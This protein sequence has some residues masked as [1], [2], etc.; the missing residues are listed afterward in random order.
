MIYR[1]GACTLDTQTHELYR[2]GQIVPL[3]PKVFQVLTYLIE[4]R[5]RLVTKQEL[6]AHVWLHQFVDDSV[7]ARCIMAARKA[8]GDT[9]GSPQSIITLRSQGYRFTAAVTGRV[10]AA[11][12]TAWAQGFGRPVPLP[13]DAALPRPVEDIPDWSRSHPIPTT[14]LALDGGYLASSIHTVEC[15]WVTALCCT[16]ASTTVLEAG[17]TPTGGPNFL[18]AFLDLAIPEVRRYGGTLQHVTPESFLTLFG[19]P[20]AYEDHAQRAVLAALGLRRCLRAWYAKAGLPVTPEP[21]LR[22]GLHTGLMMVGRVVDDVPI[23]YAAGEITDLAFQL[24]SGA[25]PG[26]IVASATTARLVR[27]MVRLA[28]LPSPDGTGPSPPLSSY[29]VCA[30]LPRR[31][32]ARRSG[33]WGL[34]PFAGRQRD[35]ATLHTL[36]QMVSAGRGQVVSIM[37]EPG[38]GKSRLLYE[39]CRSLEPH[40]VTYVA[41]ACVSYGRTIP[42]LPVLDVLRSHCGITAEDADAVIIAQVQRSLQEAGMAP[43]TWAP[44]LLQLLRVQPENADR[45][46]LSAP[47]SKAQICAALHQMALNS[48][49]QRPYIVVLEDLHWID[50]AS[51]D[52]VEM[53]VDRIPRAAILLLTT[54]RPGYQP[55]WMGKS[56][57]TQIALQPLE[58]EDSRQMVHH[59]LHTA[60]AAPS[61]ASS[62]LAYAE[63]NPFFLEELAHHAVTPDA[64][65]ACGPSADPVAEKRQHTLVPDTIQ[66]LLAARVDRSSLAEKHLL[67]IAAVIGMEVPLALL[68]AMAAVSEE[69][70]QH[71]LSHLQSAELLY[72]TRLGPEQTY[73]FKHR[74]LQETIYESLPPHIRQ[75]QHH[76][77]VQLLTT[78]FPDLAR[79][80]P[81]WLD[82]HYAGAGWST[83]AAGV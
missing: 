34:T 7:I 31:V 52:Y 62:I 32:V 12:A 67:H 35:L 72:E 49:R 75:Q 64:E 48:S 47:T 38:M 51:Q 50:A 13:P 45:D 43:E 80:Q 70:L 44:A 1:F 81:E 71:S 29:H 14:P 46:L 79:T 15:K 61:L 42:Y 19:A 2:E 73:T 30:M 53:L 24:A 27:G 55:T 5:H 54:F 82:R 60:A 63:G 56:Y 74:L 28:A 3:Q 33:D 77:L 16:L 39:F 22:L 83:V 25:A 58:P 68:R 40:R 9:Q 8:I 17:H 57:A 66:A 23:L 65:G 37:G 10:E 78:R 69:V 18:H 59:L 21:T 4:H 36:L 26:A 6:L 76:R 41:G 20:I 11:G